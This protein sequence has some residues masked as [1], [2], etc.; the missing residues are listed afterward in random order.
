[1]TITISQ[2]FPISI[3]ISI[4]ISLTKTYIQVKKI[5]YYDPKKASPVPSVQAGGLETADCSHT[6]KHPSFLPSRA[7]SIQVENLSFRKVSGKINEIT[8][9]SHLYRLVNVTCKI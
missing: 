9:F 1:M 3:E 2:S 6:P 4:T 8:G 5:Y 7:F